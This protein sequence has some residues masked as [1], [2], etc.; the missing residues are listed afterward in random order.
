MCV[1]LFLRRANQLLDRSDPLGQSPNPLQQ[2]PEH[3][4]CS[5]SNVHL[6]HSS[7]FRLGRGPQEEGRTLQEPIWHSKDTVRFL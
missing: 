5:I 4:K 2:G 7:V 3:P 6:L 1:G